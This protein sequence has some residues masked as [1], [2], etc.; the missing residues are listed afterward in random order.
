MSIDQ[1]PVI[2]I[3]VAAAIIAAM[4]LPIAV[5]AAP[6][7]P[8]WVREVAAQ[9]PSG[10]P[11]GTSAVVLVEEASVVVAADG[12]KKQRERV[13]YRILTSEGRRLAV[14]RTIYN[15]AS[16]K[17]VSLVAWSVDS[18][19]RITEFGR[20]RIIEAATYPSSLE[21]YGDYWGAVINASG[22][23]PVG[24]TFAFEAVVEEREVFAQDRFGFQWS[25]PVLKSSF[26]AT[27]PTGWSV[28]GRTFNADSVEPLVSG[29][30]TT[31]TMNNLPAWPDEPRGPSA[32]AHGPWLAI[33]YRRSAGAKGN[34]MSWG[35][36]SW[37]A[38]SEHFTPYY[39]SAS[40]PDDSI[41]SRA[42]ALTEGIAPGWEQVRAL[43]TFAQ[44]V[45]YISIAFNTP[46][47]GGMIP[48]QAKQVL[49]CGYG[50]CK[51]K[52]TLLLSL[53]SAK[54]VRAY[55]AT[56]F[57]G[58]AAR[59]QE[60]WPS[61][62]QFNH[63]IVAI[64]VD[65]SVT[66]PAVVEH[67]TLGRLLFFDPT[68]TTAPV[69]IL[70]SEDQ[71][72]LA[73][74]L[75]GDAG[76]LVR[77]PVATPDDNHVR[78]VIRVQLDRA[79]GIKGTIREEFRGN[80]SV[81]ERAMIRK[82]TP[83]RYHEIVER[84][85]GSTM[86]GARARRIEP[87]DDFATAALDVEVEFEAPGHGRLMRDAL[88]VFK[89]V[90]VSRRGSALLRPGERKSPVVF[91]AYSLSETTEF[92]LPEGFRVDEM[93]EPVEVESQFGWY[94]ARGRLGEEGRL[95]FERTLKLLPVV[96]PASEYAEVRAFYERIIKAEQ[97]PVVLA[98]EP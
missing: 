32:S 63:C 97:S 84:W 41:K 28:E 54:G 80:A 94:S 92:E 5:S 64:P 43:C 53:L 69:G 27:V 19:G 2:R 90:L 34:L 23:V 13:A 7:A 68:N 51:D 18:N 14:A 87:V 25:I 1:R 96:V 60:S 73:L 29:S 37:R 30:T 9:R 58:D 59:I 55:A 66:G 75:A 48:R 15:K 40:E 74:V 76:E 33:D 3:V 95:I 17:L 47:G 24:S 4:C 70:P 6:K 65:A 49:A 52:S 93:V 98:R 82:N 11:E 62:F 45:N 50:D 67:S 71:G 77:L 46:V 61:P 88:I 56:V 38:I 85:I 35:F 81:D 21:L 8:E 83:T 42:A 39:S 57:S 36:D 31:W 89:P 20:K 22:E 86:P 44:S 78:R 12:T 91:D 10:F 26:S 72:S 16:G 79:G